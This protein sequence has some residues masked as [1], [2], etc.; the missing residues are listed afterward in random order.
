MQPYYILISYFP[1][2]YLRNLFLVPSQ[3][4]QK[5]AEML[6]HTF[7]SLPV[8]L[9]VTGW[10]ARGAVKRR[11]PCVWPQLISRNVVFYV[12]PRSPR[13]LCSSQ[14]LINALNQ[15]VSLWHPWACVCLCVP[16]AS[17]HFWRHFQISAIKGC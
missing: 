6:K 4:N 8:R 7:I 16:F 17:V 12:M 15:T 1:D 3:S 13:T 5:P 9:I 10:G 14:Q 2:M 11:S